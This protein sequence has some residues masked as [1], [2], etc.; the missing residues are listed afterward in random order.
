[1]TGNQMKVGK[2]VLDN[3]VMGR[4]RHNEVMCKN[5]VGLGRWLDQ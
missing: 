2:D 1:M 4:L 3:A 5:G